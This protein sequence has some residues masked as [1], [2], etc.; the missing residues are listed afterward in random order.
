MS[1]I[2]VCNN[3]GATKQFVLYHKGDELAQWQFK[4]T[5]SGFEL[6]ASDHGRSLEAA[7]I[8]AAAYDDA[9]PY[10]EREVSTRLRAH[11]LPRLEAI[12]MRVGL[13]GAFFEQHRVI[14]ELFVTTLKRS[15]STA[16]LVAPRILRRVEQMQ[17]LFPDVSLYAASDTA[18]HATMPSAARTYSLGAGSDQTIRRHGYHGLAVSSASA[19][20]H[21]VL[22][23][24]PRRLIVCYLDHETSVSALKDG[25][26][27]RTTTG[28]AN[29]SGLIATT[30][31]GDVDADAVLALMRSRHLNIDAAETH[32]HTAAG[33]VGLTGETDMRR[34]LDRC[35]QHDTVAHAA[36][37]L[38]V[39]RIAEAIGAQ[40]VALGG[41]DALVFTGTIGV[42]CDAIRERVMK[43]LECLGVEVAIDLNARCV[44]REGV[45]SAANSKVKAGVVMANE[46]RAMLAVESLVAHNQSSH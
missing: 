42:R 20:V 3:S 7:V 13:P 14:D 29:G 26:S 2:L 40:Y 32:L 35:S 37:E 10:V 18:F 33:L 4:Q 34:L 17:A 31:G 25:A 16:P 28:F 39:A 21:A 6:H 46:A 9:L 38:Y 12:V 23:V 36:L 41:C 15:V 27:I 8:T 30:A 45:I 44:S 24:E 43:Q 1:M 11:E 5:T 22:G 19:R